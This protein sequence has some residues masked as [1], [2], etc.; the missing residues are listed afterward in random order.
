VIVRTGD[1]EEVVV[2]GGETELADAVAAAGIAADADAVTPDT[3][4][5]SIEN[6]LLRERRAG[7]PKD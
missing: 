5:I 7:A 6:R 4:E 1:V 3:A 2:A